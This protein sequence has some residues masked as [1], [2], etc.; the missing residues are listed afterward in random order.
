M[1]KI[2][3]N[4][5]SYEE[6]DD[7]FIF[8]NK[9]FLFI[10]KEFSNS[11]FKKLSAELWRNFT[12]GKCEL[13]LREISGLGKFA[14]ISKDEELT[15]N[16]NKTDYEYEIE[17]QKNGIYI[18]YSKE[19]GLI[20]GFLTILQMLS[21]YRRKTGDFSIRN[22]H[23]KDKPGLIMRGIHLCIFK[24]ISLLFVKKCVALCAFLKVSHIILESWGAVRF[25]SMKELSWPDSHDK[26]ELKEIIEFGKSL[27]VEFIPF[28]NHAGHATQSRH[29]TGKHVVLDQAPEYEELFLPGGWTWN[30]DNEEVIELHRS[31]RKE[32]CEL[33]GKGEF[34]H[35]GCDEI[36][37]ENGIW[38]NTGIS[39]SEGY[40]RFLN[41]TASD[42]KENLG[43][44]T[45]IW[46]DMFLDNKDFPYPYCAN[47]NKSLTYD[48]D[49]LTK[50]M[51]IVDWQY[52]ITEEK[53]DSVKYFLEFTDPSKLILAPWRDRNKISGRINLAKKYNLFGVI[54]TT[55]NSVLFDINDMR[56][57]A[58]AMWEDEIDKNELMY[59][60][61]CHSKTM[62]MQFIRKLVP[63]T[64]YE[65]AGFT[66]DE[67]LNVII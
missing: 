33:F 66:E 4:P 18:N 17:C 16:E 26:D 3:P 59:S 1:I 61:A 40:T 27:G 42:I 32:L 54:G 65:T 44:K 45:M 11:G 25:D 14:V 5:C 50:D 58:C 52:N 39:E 63:A 67:I 6:F 10:D 41:R 9:L 23:I 35:I 29:K 7:E 38:K 24:G 48:P 22:C 37:D 64:S 13:E 56:Y 19:T 60:Y 55:W 47:T 46:G 51:Y 62:A 57:T 28:F 31:V 53:E 49:N 15:Y 43:R 20:H 30:V 21:P 2:Y 36:V 12:S 8:S 34:F